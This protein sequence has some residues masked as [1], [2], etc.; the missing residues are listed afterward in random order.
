MAYILPCEQR[1]HFRYV[2]WRSYF[3]H[4]SSHSESVASAR[5][6]LIFGR[7]RRYN[8]IIFLLKA[9]FA[10]T[11]GGGGA[12]YGICRASKC[13]R[14]VPTYTRNCKL[15]SEIADLK[16]LNQSNHGDNL[17]CH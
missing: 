7:D 11:G 4:D 3:S 15:C 14:K 17:E 2:S 16:L 1:L 13:L 9:R 6:V 8:R 5:R 12:V 10:I